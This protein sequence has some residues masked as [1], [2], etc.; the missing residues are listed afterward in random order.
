[1]SAS[2]LSCFLCHGMVQFTD[3]DPSDF[4][5]HMTNQHKAFFNME[6]SLAVTLMNEKESRAVIKGQLVWKYGVMILNI[7]DEELLTSNTIKYEH[8]GGD[9]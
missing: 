3:K 6:L 7:E 2:A 4:A 8:Y 9:A 5:S 1:M